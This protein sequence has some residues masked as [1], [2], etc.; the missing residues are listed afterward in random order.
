MKKYIANI[1]LIFA[2]LILPSYLVFI[3]KYLNVKSLHGVFSLC[4]EVV[5]GQLAVYQ[6]LILSVKS[7]FVLYV[8]PSF[9]ENKWPPT[10][11]LQFTHDQDVLPP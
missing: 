4:A 2:C 9:I 8:S 7:Q 6:R 5:E 1:I 3:R 11:C 10:H